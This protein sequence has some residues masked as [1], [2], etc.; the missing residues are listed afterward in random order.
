MLEHYKSIERSHRSLMRKSLRLVSRYL[1]PGARILDFGCG[2][3]LFV[4]EA[5]LQGYD[6]IGLDIATWVKEAAAHWRV[7]LDVCRLENAPYISESFDAVVSVVSFEHLDDPAGVLPQ[8]VNL[9][10]P[11]GVL[12]IVSIPH[13]YGLP[14]RLLKE[15]WWD[16]NP[17]SHLHFFSRH[18]MKTLLERNG[19]R[20]LR[21][22]TTGVG[23]EFFARL[24][25]K[26]P[27]QQTFMDSFQ[28][29]VNTG[30]VVEGSGGSSLLRRFATHLAIPAMDWCLDV[31]HLGN[32]LTAVAIKDVPR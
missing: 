22:R 13:G 27:D 4:L 2:P 5:R 1:E 10:R 14:C 18:S 17:P 25:R 15:Q 7:P 26:S 3:G 29:Q 28:R 20:V 24:L 21:L 6:A 12:A 11:G 8:L 16:L 23:T 19:L 31:T 30:E 9:L 32:N